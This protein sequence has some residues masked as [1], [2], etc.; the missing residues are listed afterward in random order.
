MIFS[1]VHGVQIYD[2]LLHAG[3]N[4]A[5]PAERIRALTGTDAFKTLGVYLTYRMDHSAAADLMETKE[6]RKIDRIMDSP[7]PLGAKLDA[8]RTCVTRSSEHV[9]FTAWVAPDLL[10]EL[11]KTERKAARAL[12]NHNLPNAYILSELKLASRAWRSEVVHLAGFIRALGSADLRLKAAAL[13]ISRDGA[14]LFDADKEGPKLDPPFFGWSRIQLNAGKGPSDAP[15]RYAYLA[16]KHGLSFQEVNG[17]IEINLDGRR[18]HDPKAL[19]QALSK[20][21]SKRLLTL[22]ENR[23]ST[24]PNRSPPPPYSI[25]WGLAGLPDLDRWMASHFLGPHTTFTDTEIRVLV[26]L[27][28]YLWP[29]AWRDSIRSENKVTGK[30]GCGMYQTITHILN[31]EPTDRHHG[32]GLRSVRHARHAALLSALKDWLVPETDT[33][34]KWSVVTTEGSRGDARW[35]TQCEAVNRAKVMGMLQQ[36]GDG[37]QHYKPDLV[38]GNKNDKLIYIIDVSYGSDDKL[39]KEQELIDNWD[40]T[41]Q[42]N[43]PHTLSPDFWCGSW[44]DSESRTTEEGTAALGKEAMGLTFKHARY[45]KRY[46]NLRKILTESTRGSKVRIIPL[47]FGVCGSTPKF[48]MNYLKTLTNRTAAKLFRSMALKTTQI[49]AVKAYRFF[50]NEQPLPQREQSTPRL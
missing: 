33:T 11:D 29:T 15:L 43:D 13:G 39:A 36:D 19:L 34:T 4:G 32:I 23:I 48:T 42:R 22:L 1:S 26:G 38:I 10:A 31:V 2:P 12:L 46:Q 44:F 40:A 18:V 35:E 8:L 24:N 41:R 16:H 49:H 37:S 45:H 9:F 30:C 47:A 17:H 7:F 21:R 14:P 5:G 50:M 6:T 3:F 20:R 28:L 25:S 27:R